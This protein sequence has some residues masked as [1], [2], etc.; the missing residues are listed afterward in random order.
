M[1]MEDKYNFL[2]TE[3]PIKKLWEN[4]K[5][6][7]F[8]T[9]KKPVFSIDTPPP[10]VSGSLHIGH[11]FSYTQADIIARFARMSGY[12]VF[13]P[14]GFDDNGLAT[15]RFVEKKR[16]VSPFTIGQNA[17]IKACLE[18][19]YIAEQQ[20]KDLW[21]SVGLSVDWNHWYS[22]ISQPVRKISQESFVR[23][24]HAEHVYRK[25]EPALYCTTCRTSVAQAELDDKTVDTE[26]YDLAFIDSDGQTLLI[27][28][29]RPELLPSCVAIFYHPDDARYTKLKN[30]KAVVPLFDYEV[31]ILAD[32]LVEPAKG[33]GL[34]MCCTFGDKN[35]ITWFKKH[36]P[37]YRQSIERDGKWSKQTNFLAGLK[38]EQARKEIV[39]KLIEAGKLVNQKPITHSVNIHERCKK[40][41][42]YLIIPQWFINIL[43]HKKDFLACGEKIVWHP[44]YMKSRYINWVENLGWDWCI[45]R[46]RFSGIPFP[47]WH[48][49]ACGHIV[50][51]S[52]DQL[53]VDPRETMINDGICPACGKKELA[54]ETDVMDTWNTSSLTPYICQSLIS[55]DKKSV[56][57]TTAWFL[58]MAMR[59]QAH[60]II[61]TWA[62]YTIVKAWFHNKTIPWKTIVISGHVLSS[63]A[64]KISKSQ[65]NAPTDPVKLVAT[66]SAD[67]VRFWT[68]SSTL[69][70]DTA[71]SESQIKIGQK[72]VTKLFNA[73]R[74]LQTH[75]GMCTFKKKF[76]IISPVNRWIFH[77]ATQTFAAYKKELEKKEFGLALAHIEKLFWHFFCDNYLELIKSQLFKPEEYTGPEL[78]ETQQTLYQIG[79]QILQLYAPYMPFITEHLYQ[80]IYHE[81]IATSSIHRTQFAVIQ[82][83]HNYPAESAIIESLLEIIAA[84]RKLKT[85]HQLAL[86]TTIDELTIYTEKPEL[87]KAINDNHKLLLGVTRALNIK[88]SDGQGETHI[89]KDNDKI[90]LFLNMM[91]S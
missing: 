47:V 38:V 32:E 24:Y 51:A 74:F 68:A 85:A 23:L 81:T 9:E 75:T 5:T 6:F 27:S 31:P 71:F 20:F 1:I 11:I 25:Q 79:L 86:A 30:K 19:T 43:D 55:K 78:E 41:I 69:G 39:A 10:T 88:I 45:S 16:G 56:F 72:T 87:K 53:P 73:F 91:S 2:K 89:V 58:P 37:P 42:E 76:A 77:A 65:G 33:T 8:N 59:P 62:F 57:D 26:F 17:F 28:T 48:C 82:Q 15:E 66:W 52:I 7:V 90:K 64:Q 44:S 12:E 80:H 67:A 49:L 35:D 13:Y 40:E 63:V 50:V 61:R 34:V 36:K 29:T 22:T 21:Q 4:E 3:E 84:V 46:Q 60:D 18:E 54:P 83:E 70:T 14:F